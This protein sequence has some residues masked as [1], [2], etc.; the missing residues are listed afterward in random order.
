MLAAT[1]E[2]EASNEQLR[3]IHEEAVSVNEELQSTNEELEASKEELQSLNEELTTVNTQLGEKMEELAATNND[4]LNLFGATEIATVFLDK[5]LRLRRFT[6]AAE[7]LLNLIASDLG[8]PIGHL[9]QN[10][11]GADLAATAE[12][13]LRDLSVVEREVIG[14]DGRWYTLRAF[15]YRR[16]DDRIDGVVVT[17][18]EVTR[19]KHIEQAL[20][21]TQA[22]AEARAEQ[23]E[24]GRLLLEAIQEAVPPLIAYLDRD[25]IFRR[26]STRYAEAAGLPREEMEGRSYLAVFPQSEE[27]VS[28]L[29]QALYQAE[30][31]EVGEFFLALTRRPGAEARYWDMVFRP[32]RSRE[33]GAAGVVMSLLDVTDRVRQRRRVEEAERARAELAETLN[34]EIAHRVKNNLAMVAGLLQMQ[35]AE[36]P[37]TEISAILRNTTG[38]LLALANVHE[39]M[40]VVGEGDLDL[41]RVIRHIARANREAFAQKRVVI[42][43]QGE[44]ALLPHKAVTNLAVV[45]NEL[46]TNA[47]KHGAAPPDGELRVDVGV[48]QADGCL[49]LSVW[50]SG[51]P[52]PTDFET[53]KPRTMGLRLVAGLSIEQYGGTFSLRPHEGGTM[54]EVVVEEARLN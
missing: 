44:P 43:V 36:H 51:H 45:A 13:V 6:P 42:S 7:G 12:V 49:R 37:D 30:P 33:G 48:H 18:A 14:R 25:L 22:E 9:S 26:V 1:V 8:R 2:F 46:I 24:E 11:T 19:L 41:L 52:V 27:V 10:F 4:L 23:A 29:Q 20:E 3:A 40:Q 35:I 5:D 50:N 16:S 39:Q 32:V 53:S 17:L 47:V 54:A 15:P 21:A 38:R 31:V 34:R 28:W